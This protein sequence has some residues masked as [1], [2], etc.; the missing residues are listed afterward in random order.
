MQT[1]IRYAY[2]ILKQLRKSYAT[3]QF[4]TKFVDNFGWIPGDLARSLIGRIFKLLALTIQ[5]F[6]DLAENQD[7]M[8]TM[9]V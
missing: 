1:N 9:D 5:S 2:K 4:W 7:S 6:L 8:I 3:S